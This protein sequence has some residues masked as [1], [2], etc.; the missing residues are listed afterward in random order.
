MDEK[1]DG[2]DGC[3]RFL[4]DYTDEQG[5]KVFRTSPEQMEV[6]RKVL[7]RMEED[8]LKYTEDGVGHTDLFK[9]ASRALTA[10]FQMNMTIDKMRQDTFSL[11][12]DEDSYMYADW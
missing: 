8:G 6:M 5:E 1:Y 9:F 3:Y 7:K 4:K 12:K 2:P 11:D 10:A